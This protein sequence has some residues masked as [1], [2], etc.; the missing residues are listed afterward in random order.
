MNE[1]VAFAS[2]A[3]AIILQKNSRRKIKMKRNKRMI[4]AMLIFSMVLSVFYG[5]KPTEVQAASK[6]K[7][8]IQWLYSGWHVDETEK[9]SDPY[10]V[11]PGKT[12]AGDEIETDIDFQSI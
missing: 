7:V 9:W 6:P 12:A 10:Y 5:V 1:N 11:S 3:G 4:V 2:R 8:Q